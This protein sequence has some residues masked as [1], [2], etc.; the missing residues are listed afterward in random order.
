MMSRGFGWGRRES[1]GGGR[2]MRMQ[3]LYQLEEDMD[4]EE[5]CKSLLSWRLWL[6]EGLVRALC[7]QCQYRSSHR[8]R[9]WSS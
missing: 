3:V 7:G 4:R 5:G 2:G 6:C 1:W 8:E 9:A